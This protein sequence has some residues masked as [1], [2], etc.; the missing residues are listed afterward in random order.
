MRANIDHSQYHKIPEAENL[1]IDILNELVNVKDYE[2][3]VPGFEE[4]EFGD[5]LKYICTG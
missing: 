1:K 4:K 2:Y 3:T 5:I